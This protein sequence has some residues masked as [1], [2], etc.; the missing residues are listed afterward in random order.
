VSLQV[1]FIWHQ[2]HLSLASQ[3]LKEPL[4]EE[5]T[6]I[7]KEESTRISSTLSSISRIPLQTSDVSA[8]NRIDLSELVRLR[9]AHQT[10]QARK[11]VR[12]SKRASETTLQPQ[13]VDEFSEFRKARHEI[14]QRFHQLLR[15]ADAEGERVGTGLHR[16]AVWNTSN[17]NTLNAEKAAA[18]RTRTV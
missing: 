1:L 17:G 8:T 4:A 15:D 7:Y 11:G 10:V 13:E 12:N 5:I 14:V 6:Q 2:P 16:K 9:A 18:G 3:K